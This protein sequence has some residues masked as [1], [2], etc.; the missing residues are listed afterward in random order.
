MARSNRRKVSALFY[1]VN[2][3]GLGHLSR[4]LAIARE[5]RDLLDALAVP[6]DLRFLTTSDAAYI[7][8]D[9]PVYKIPSK[10][11]AAGTAAAET[12]IADSRFFVSNLVASLRPDLLVLD[13]IPEGSFNEFLMIRD[14]A[15]KTVFVDRH[16]DP[17]IRNGKLQ[18][19]ML[20]LYDR[21]LVPDDPDE[22]R[23]P[24]PEAL[25]ERRFFT[26]RIHGFRPRTAFS[27]EKAR[28]QLGVPDGSVLIY[29]SAGG[30]G[31]EAAEHQLDILTETLAE[32][33]SHFL[34]VGYG[35]LYSG[36]VRYGANIANYHGA[37]V[38]RFFPALDLA[39]SAAGYNTYQELITARV[40]TLFY[41]QTKGMDRQEERI[42][43]GVS[44]GLHRK[45]TNLDTSILR[46]AVEDMKRA[47]TQAELRDALVRHPPARGA[48]S[49]AVQLLD[50][51][52]VLGD[53][54]VERSALIAA[55]ACARDWE[56]NAFF[57]QCW[58][59]A[60]IWLRCD[61]L[62]RQN[63][64]DDALIAWRSGL[65]DRNLLAL[66]K[67]TAVIETLR[68]EAGISE[69]DFLKIIDR[70]TAA[71]PPL[72]P[73]ALRRAFIDLLTS[74]A[75]HRP[76]VTQPLLTALTLHVK[77]ADMA[78][79]C[80]ELLSRLPHLPD[81]HDFIDRLNTRTK[82]LDLSAFSHFLDSTCQGA[83]HVSDQG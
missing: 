16:R 36:K 62:Y 41:A 56:P 18:K 71:D 76:G 29:V 11:A 64:M 3:V 42:D 66:G 63:T 31:D 53:S 9:F 26:G 39:V 80:R 34:L 50:L 46:A 61:K 55:A 6:T 13:T 7:A 73:S 68:V 79:A 19:N 48:L 14:F 35:P 47:D 82:M 17:K 69:P 52:A 75:E 25:A 23:Y 70:F 8:G 58:R 21:I 22:A 57:P 51:H 4:L 60:E 40:P 20:A 59:Q 32:D 67:D 65:A 1:A 43:R 81:F 5:M 49:A 83:S 28:E 15:R 45:L 27:R 44:A 72:A 74:L 54:A 33:P 38:S 37:A 24:L 10:T 77:R 12:F 30:G 78:R 2:G